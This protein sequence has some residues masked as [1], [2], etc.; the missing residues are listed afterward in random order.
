MRESLT[1]KCCHRIIK[2]PVTLNCCSENICK[3]DIVEL[4]FGNEF[5]CPCCNEKN[6]NQKL[7]VNMLI[8]GLLENELHN[9]P[10]NQEFVETLEN[11]K[12]Q[13]G[14]LEQDLKNGVLNSCF[15]KI[16]SQISELKRKVNL[17]KNK[18]KKQTDKLANKLIQQL[19]LY[20]K[21]FKTNYKSKIKHYDDLVQV[22]KQQLDE[23][24]R[25]LSL[26]SVTNEERDMKRMNAENVI[27]NL[28]PKLNELK[29]DLLSKKA[30]T[31]VPMQIS[32]NDSF[33][34]LIIEVKFWFYLT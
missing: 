6:L 5:I 18:L 1:C 22:S 28:L 24:E 30:I 7:N 29:S 34:K 9:F 21:K 25:C 13:I 33:S 10:I 17:D 12:V 14:N 8:Q 16:E 27:N 26:F 19:E 3:Q 11:L 15:N 23:Y 20:E 4:M 31:Y 2:D 32:I